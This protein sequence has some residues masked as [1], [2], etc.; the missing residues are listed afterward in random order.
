MPAVAR[1]QKRNLSQPDEVRP[2]GRGRLEVVAL[3]DSVLG[4]ISYEPGWRWS[5]DVR[6]IVKTELCEVHHVGYV[7][8][9]QLHTEMRD[10]SV[11]EVRAGDVFEF[12]P[13]HDAWVIGDEPW[14]SI[15]WAGRRYFGQAPEAAAERTLATILFTDIVGST[16]LIARIG[17]HAWHDRLAEYHAMVRRA[18]E[19]HR[20]REVQTTGDGVLATFSSTAHA[21]QCAIDTARAAPS[22]GLEQRAGL[23]TGEVEFSGDDVRG[24][25]VHVAA[26]VAAA[27]GAGEVLVSATTNSLLSGSGL[28]TVSRGTHELKGVGQ[29]VELFAVDR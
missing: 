16:Q 27:A 23:H 7:V 8:S 21:A 10:G 28:E 13:G 20:G 15:D 5:E 12:P 1:L 3:G 19:R 22:L 18:L 6:P 11:M 26:R 17:D 4:R 9:G 29:P 14:V 2:V 25:A 24:I